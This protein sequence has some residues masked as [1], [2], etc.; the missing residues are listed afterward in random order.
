M[1]KKERA[2]N[3]IEVLKKEY[4][5]AICSLNASNP[6]E[7]LVAVRLSAQCTDARVN[8]VTPTLFEKY[9]TLD[10][11]CNADVKDI[12]KII[13]SC[14]FYK[15]KAESII[16]MAKGVRDRFGGTVP[17]NIEDLTTL[18]GVG[19]KTA[20]LIVGDVYG[21]ESIV[22]DT[23]MIRI[24]NRI[25]LVTEKDPKK[26][27]FALKKIVPANEGSDFCH[28]IVLFG[29]DICSARKPKCDICPMEFNCKK[30]GINK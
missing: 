7:L 12:E 11:Y 10:D 9:K 26:I 21:K 30:V 27:E 8:I 19:R 6:F 14:G 2:L 13:H 5:E 25:G 24:A 15:S 4:P 23:H 20:N 28:R 22:V 16:D 1:T 18:N 3:A 29:R 17:D